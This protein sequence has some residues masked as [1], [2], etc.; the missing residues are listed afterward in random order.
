M[1]FYCFSRCVQSW[2]DTTFPGPTPA[3]AK[4]WPAIADGDHTLV[5]APTGSGKTLAA[6]LWALD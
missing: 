6:F 4:A 3:Q 2:F 1:S 5:L